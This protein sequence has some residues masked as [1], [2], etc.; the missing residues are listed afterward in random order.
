MKKP[1]LTLRTP[2]VSKARV[3]Y[4]HPS[5]AKPALAQLYQDTA[6]ALD[7][8]PQALRA[9]AVVESD[10]KPFTQ[11]GAP[12]VRLEIAHW[13]RN[14]YASKPALA[15]DR[16]VNSGDLDVRWA[17]FQAMHR[18][19]P[20]AAIL[21]HSF[22]LF[23][24]MGFNHLACLCATPEAFLA[25]VMSLEGQFRMVERLILSSPDLLGALRRQDAA[26]VALHYNGK[27]YAQNRYDVRWAAAVK[28][29]GEGVWA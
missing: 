14:R 22:G 3:Y 23:Q 29:G 1:T 13:K 24:I 10:E 11:G 12:V 9:L 19:Q 16:C 4:D 5:G 27:A 7:I 15:F 28:A 6:A 17:Q 26:R 25:E 21:A 8:K 20:E 2:A 18:C